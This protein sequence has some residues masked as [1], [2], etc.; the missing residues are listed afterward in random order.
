MGQNQVK[1]QRHGEGEG[2]VQNEV[3]RAS[4]GWHK[5]HGEKQSQDES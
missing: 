1:Y 4:G 2:L 3:E 5:D